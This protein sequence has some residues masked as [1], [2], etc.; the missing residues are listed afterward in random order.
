MTEVGVWISLFCYELMKIK[1]KNFTTFDLRI[2]DHIEYETK[3]RPEISWSLQR[4]A[5][6]SNTRVYIGKLSWVSDLEKGT[7]LVIWIS[8]KFPALELESIS[9]KLR[10]IG[11]HL[12]KD[13][14]HSMSCQ[15]YG[16]L[17]PEQEWHSG[18][19]TV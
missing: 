18:Y 13:I 12:K 17:K 6:E 14:L 9:L 2:S 8:L 7:N 19:A 16:R 5:V 11:S 10:F 3:S 15:P 4:E 1:V